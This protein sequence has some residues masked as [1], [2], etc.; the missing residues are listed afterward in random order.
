LSNARRRLSI[1][2]VPQGL[3]EQGDASESAAA[4]GFSATTFPSR[5]M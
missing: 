1:H 3:A 5:Q 4:Q 2:H